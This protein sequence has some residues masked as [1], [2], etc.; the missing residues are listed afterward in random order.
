MSQLTAMSFLVSKESSWAFPDQPSSGAF[1]T[2]TQLNHYLNYL[3]MNT[4]QNLNLN[5]LN[6]LHYKQRV[7]DSVMDNFIISA[8]HGGQLLI[9]VA[10]TAVIVSLIMM[11]RRST[12]RL[13]YLFFRI[14]TEKI[15]ELINRCDCFAETIEYLSKYSVNSI[16]VSKHIMNIFAGKGKTKTA[17]DEELGGDKKRRSRCCPR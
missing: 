5:V 11:Y 1:P 17:G 15:T 2:S 8:I 12:D 9:L 14:R 3:W 7:S 13:I 6:F 10:L 16:E 4:L